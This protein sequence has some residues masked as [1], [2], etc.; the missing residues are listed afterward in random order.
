MMTLPLLCVVVLG[1][2]AVRLV[3]ADVDLTPCTVDLPVNE[4]T[5]KVDGIVTLHDGR[6]MKGTVHHVGGCRQ[7]DRFPTGNPYRTTY[8]ML[9]CKVTFFWYQEN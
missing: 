7:Q 4:M 8:T 6:Q 1:V 2:A 3:A 9:S 5:T